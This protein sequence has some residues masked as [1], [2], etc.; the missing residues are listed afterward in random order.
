[1]LRLA[2]FASYKNEKNVFLCKLS[3]AGFA[4]QGYDN[5]LQC[6]SCGFKSNSW[7]DVG[8]LFVQHAE[9]APE[10][11]F[12]QQN[13]K[14]APSVDSL[15][16]CKREAISKDA[17]A[18]GTS[19]T[20]VCP[21]MTLSPKSGYGNQKPRASN[22]VSNRASAKSVFQ[23][24]GIYIDSNRA[25][26]PSYAVLVNRVQSFTSANSVFHKSPS[27]MA[28]AGFFYKG[29]WKLYPKD[30]KSLCQCMY[31]LN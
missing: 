23:N 18:A 2:T 26:F 20:D 8:D 28:M 7:R 19:S 16:N 5:A 15:N 13:R 17:N 10:C 27:E 30:L 4:Y 3:K 1:M 29:A 25:K 12:V 11:Q 14:N 22:N 31:S 24:L 6:E 9:H 21:K